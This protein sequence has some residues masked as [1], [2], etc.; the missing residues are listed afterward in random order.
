MTINY[1]YTLYCTHQES[2]RIPKGV[3]IMM[4]KLISA[5]L[6][7]VLLCAGLATAQAAYTPGT[8]T[9]V[10]ENGRNGAVK[11]SV[12][13]SE[14]AIS[15]IQIV[16]HEETPGLSDPA[17]TILPENIVAAQ[18]LAVDT[19]GGA[20][21]SS[22]AVLEAV[23]DAVAQAGGDVEAL[24]NTKVEKKVST[25]VVEL[26]ANMVVVGGGAAGLAAAVTVACEG[27]TNIIL[28]EKEGALGG[29]AIRSGGFIEDLDPTDAIAIET[30]DGYNAWLEELVAAG[31]QDELEA[32]VWDE[33]TTAY[34]AWKA[35]G[36]TRLF[37]CPA[38]LAIEYYH[39]EGTPP[40][41][42]MGY[43]ALVNEFDHWF[44]EEIGGKYHSQVGIVGY[45]WPRWVFPD[46]FERGTG[47]F[48]YMTKY[49]DEKKLDI[50]I[51]LSTAGT[52]L[53]VNENGAVTGIVAVAADG[54]TYRINAAHGVML[55]TGGFAAN[56]EMLA[57]Y[58]EQWGI[59]EGQQV[60][61][62][63][64][65]GN[66]GD[67]ILM[68][69]KIGAA[70]DG[71]ANIMMFPMGDINDSNDVSGVGIFNGSSNLF[72]NTEGKRFV[73]ET[74]SRFE[75]CHAVFAQSTPISYIITDNINSGLAG[76][77]EEAIAK[78]VEHGSL[79]RGNTIA[80]L[81][82]AMGVEPAVLEAT[83]A[84]YNEACETYH[85]ELFGRATFADG[86]A[87]V[88]APFYATPQTPVAHITIGGIVTDENG[89]VLN[90]DGEVISGLF[91]A[92]E[93][94]NGSC[95]LSA[96]AYGRAIAKY[97]VALTK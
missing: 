80:E 81:A 12:T 10:S 30:N 58:D 87:I 55:A 71:M 35:S 17:L 59:V 33:L 50:N 88:E 77:S 85:D 49:I 54:T 5:M 8:Y 32:A 3:W 44:E 21:I 73:D 95:G 40:I 19:I 51:M 6:T 7:A 84:Q 20:T 75:I 27:E 9:G 82:E 66:T 48:H 36:S 16:E 72:V 90:T 67:G 14:D 69:E 24:K 97:M 65:P 96:F 1:V 15:G 4:K 64:N 79:Y 43:P 41:F 45:T 60:K 62:D 22:K 42:N 86:S 91:A 52:E 13:F 37:D 11:V 47:Y 28:L 34:D 2:I 31:P 29:N 38:L 63:N 57:K 76:V 92:G 94:V 46:G 83:V 70:L 89:Q 25:E 39:V 68:A 74:A 18:S 26:D 61:H 78:S 93:T 23:A 56:S 53:I